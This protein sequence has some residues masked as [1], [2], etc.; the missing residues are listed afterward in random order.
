MMT[1]FAAIFGALPIALG[2]GEGAELRQPLGV[3]VVGGLM[4]SQLLTLFI[5]PVIYLYLDRIDRVLKR[6]LEPQLEE[7]PSIRSG[8]PPSRPSDWRP[9]PPLETF[10]GAC[11]ASGIG[12]PST[13]MTNLLRR[14]PACRIMRRVCAWRLRDGAVI[15]HCWPSKPIRAIIPFGAGSATDVVPRIVFD[16]LSRAAWPA[17]RRGEPR[18]RRRHDRHRNGRQGRARRLHHPGDSSAHTITPSIYPQPA[19]DV[20]TRF[21]GRRRRSA[22][23]PNALIIAPSKGFKTLQDFVLAAKAK[24]ALSILPRSASVP[25]YI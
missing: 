19:Y 2:S 14:F 8:R 17:D 15:A 3:A 18:G 24:P 6:R 11:A 9:R 7:V 12:T 22:M 23:Y 21:R 10:H 16:Q 5:T 20:G 1:T 13:Q 25:R 4:V